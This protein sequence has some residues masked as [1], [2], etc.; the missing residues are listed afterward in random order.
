[1]SISLTGKKSSFNNEQEIADTRALLLAM[2]EDGGFNT[3]GSYSANSTLYPDNVIPFVDKHIQ[4][5]S[6]HTLNPH[7]YLSNLRLMTKIR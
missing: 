5:L 3:T 7:Q 2:V 4:Y 1:M 6:T